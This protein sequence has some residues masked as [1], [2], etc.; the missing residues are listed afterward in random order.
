M[1][2][3]GGT[4]QIE[5]NALGRPIRE[6]TRNDGDSGQDIVL[7]IDATLQRYCMQRL[8]R[9][10]SAAAVVLDVNNGDILA[11]A[12]WPSFDPNEFS[13]GIPPALW[14]QLLADTR[15]PLTNKAVSGQYAPGST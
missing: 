9:E 14:R 2:G 12:S 8:S 4:S 13:T 10:E 11:A 3:R 1:R 5:V 7:T 15:G 6:L